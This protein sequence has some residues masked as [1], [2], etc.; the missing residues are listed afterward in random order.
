MLHGFYTM[1]L[2]PFAET[3]HEPYWAALIE[4]YPLFRLTS[5]FHRRS[6]NLPS[7]CARGVY[8]P[9]CPSSISYMSTHLFEGDPQRVL[10]KNPEHSCNFGSV[11]FV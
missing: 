1:G 8:V 7:A 4:R 11:V 9:S 10:F 6:N 3:I 2:V 5:S